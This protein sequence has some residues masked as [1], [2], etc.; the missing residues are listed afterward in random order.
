MMFNKRSVLISDIL[1]LY[2]LMVS[3]DVPSHKHHHFFGNPLPYEAV[4]AHV[5]VLQS[6]QPLSHPI[7]IEQ[8]IIIIIQLL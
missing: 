2:S 4:Y 6:D 7:Q 5:H 3:K 1:S 8:M